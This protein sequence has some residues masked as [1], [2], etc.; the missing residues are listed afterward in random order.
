MQIYCEDVFFLASPVLALV[1]RVD[2]FVR[3]QA[4]IVLRLALEMMQ[5]VEGALFEVTLLGQ[6]NCSRFGALTQTVPEVVLLTLVILRLACLC[7]SF[8][9][10][11]KRER[12]AL[13]G[14]FIIIQLEGVG[15]PIVLVIIAGDGWKRNTTNSLANIN[16][17]IG[18]WRRTVA[19]GGSDRWLCLC[20]R[21]R[22]RARR[23][24]SSN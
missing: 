17:D 3:H 20:C 14:N 2:L 16:A 8:W 9:D 1:Y 11:G 18:W 5:Q 4:S 7:T 10:L 15:L 6:C 21:C 13:G 19:S 22:H 24:D 12:P 23:C